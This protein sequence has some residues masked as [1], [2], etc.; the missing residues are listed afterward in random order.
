M[1]GWRPLVASVLAVALVAHRPRLAVVSNR[2][3]PRIASDRRPLRRAGVTSDD[4]RARSADDRVGFLLAVADDSAWTDDDRAGVIVAARSGRARGAELTDEAGRARHAAERRDASPARAANGQADDD[5]RV[6]GSR[7]QAASAAAGVMCIDVPAY[8]LRGGVS[9]RR[10][11]QPAPQ[12][13]GP[14]AVGGAAAPRIP[15]RFQRCSMPIWS[16]RRRRCCSSTIS[17]IRPVPDAPEGPAGDRGGAYQ[18]R[19]QR[20]SWRSCS[21]SSRRRPIPARRA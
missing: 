18:Q 13:P 7:L 9:Q 21:G 12:A 11:R 14:R 3:T 4:E 20:R 15:P 5:V 19:A 1:A 17:S 6:A 8:R 2:G 10:R 16:C